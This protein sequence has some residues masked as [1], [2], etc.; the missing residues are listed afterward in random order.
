M[1]DNFDSDIYF[2]TNEVT[3]LVE[4][5]DL[6]GVISL[7]NKKHIEEKKEKIPIA[8][9]RDDL[10]IWNALYSRETIRNGSLKKYL[11]PVYN[12]FYTRIKSA[13]SLDKLQSIE[14]DM[15]NTYFEILINGIEV[16][17]N[18]II[19]KVIGFLHTHIE[20]HVSLEE[21]AEKFNISIGYLS[22]I[23]KSVTG[24]SVMTYLKNI[25]IDR[26][27]VLLTTTDMNIL[28]I[29]TLL[30]FCNQGNFTRTFKKITGM[31]PTEYRNSIP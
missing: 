21:I 18:L 22:S 6:Q 7:T 20:N 3:F 14:L 15:I 2:F 9:K 10:I 19:N 12:K 4:K 28:D 11:H 1:Y 17:N 23:F 24:M 8:T 27:K 30:C 25:K 16:T 26:A 29:S 5:R 31:T 13:T